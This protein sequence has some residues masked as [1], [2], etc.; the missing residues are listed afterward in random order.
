MSEC[1][2][3]E[4]WVA[5]ALRVEEGSESFSK[6]MPVYEPHRESIEAGLSWWDSETC[7]F[8][9]YAYR[10][11]DQWL[12]WEKLHEELVESGAFSADHYG[13]KAD[14]ATNQS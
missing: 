10:N 6:A 11:L 3:L 5:W 13:V 9:V 8:D 12:P 2:S 7:D 1:Y 4:D 14:H